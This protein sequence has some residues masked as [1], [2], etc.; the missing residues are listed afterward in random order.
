MSDL[1]AVLAEAQRIG[2]IGPGD[3][4]AAIEQAKSFAAAIP[5]DARR[6]VD[7][8]SGGGLPGLVVLSE[9]RELSLTMVD[10]KE[11]SCDLL[12]RGIRALRATDRATV[13]HADLETLGHDPDWR[14]QFDAATA[15]GVAPPPEVAELVLPLVRAGGVLVV[16]VAGDGDAWPTEGLTTVGAVVRE[17]R[18]GLVIVEAGTCPDEYP[19]KRRQ[20]PLFHVKHR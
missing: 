10:R 5:T 15:R 8:G 7:V 20:P 17:R 13:V 4:G 19:R 6:V 12:R 9:R 3:L 16:S 14:G 2:L 18:D 11:R 1:D